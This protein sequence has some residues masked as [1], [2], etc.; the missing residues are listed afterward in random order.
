MEFQ[1]TPTS[2]LTVGDGWVTVPE[3]D[4]DNR[5]WSWQSVAIDQWLNSWW[6]VLSQLKSVWH[7]LNVYVP[8]ILHSCKLKS[9]ERCSRSRK[10][11]AVV[12]ALHLRAKHLDENYDIAD[13]HCR[14][15]QK[16]ARWNSM[17]FRVFVCTA[18]EGFNFECEKPTISDEWVVL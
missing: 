3:G 1:P 12:L 4:R 7:W 9:N 5:K 2:A 17:Q 10:K 11:F 14:Q 18:K 15:Q 16:I 13:P 6:W 8:N